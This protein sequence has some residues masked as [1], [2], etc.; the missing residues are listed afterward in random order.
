MVRQPSG[1][2]QRVV[3]HT[4]TPK[5]GAKVWLPVPPSHYLSSGECIKA[6]LCAR[7]LAGSHAERGSRPVL[8]PRHHVQVTLTPACP[9]VPGHRCR[10]TWVLALPTRMCGRASRGAHSTICSA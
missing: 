7:P 8:E 9:C 6:L 10:C 5:P 4:T 3:P 2:V 1:D